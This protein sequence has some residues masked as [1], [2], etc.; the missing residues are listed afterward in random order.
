[1]SSPKSG[2]SLA[3]LLTIAVF[4]M[5]LALATWHSP[6]DAAGEP[7]TPQDVADGYMFLDPPTTAGQNRV[8]FN[9]VLSP[10]PTGGQ[11]HAGHFHAWFGAWLDCN[12]DGYIGLGATAQETYR[13]E[14]LAL[15]G[16]N[17]CPVG[18]PNN[19]GITVKE[20]R[21]IGPGSSDIPDAN[22]AVWVDLGVPGAPTSPARTSTDT[23][24]SYSNTATGARWSSTQTFATSQSALAPA[25]STGYGQ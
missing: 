5:P 6:G 14:I 1:M 23:T 4:T 25:Y 17:P 13:S 7:N 21:W 24:L 9:L 18:G 19:D 15:S 20:F 2:P 12:G 8:Y 3:F 11:Q 10:V 22:S 16:P